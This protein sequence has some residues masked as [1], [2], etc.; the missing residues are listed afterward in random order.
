MST[1]VQ[2]FPGGKVLKSLLA[3]AR[4]TDVIPGS[5]RFHMPVRQTT[6]PVSSRACELQQMRPLTTTTEVHVL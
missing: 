3:N 1:L 4:D 6:E 2:D 5:G